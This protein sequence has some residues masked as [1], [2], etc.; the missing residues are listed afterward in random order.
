MGWGRKKKGM[1]YRGD[2]TLILNHKLEF[3][4]MERKRRRIPSRENHRNRTWK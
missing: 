3:G 2:R 4:K 1:F